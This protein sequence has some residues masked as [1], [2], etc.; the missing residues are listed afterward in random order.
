MNVLLL[1]TGQVP[2]VPWSE[3]LPEPVLSADGR[4]WQVGARRFP[5]LAGG[6]DDP[7]PTD[8]PKPPEAKPKEGDGDGDDGAPF[9]KER[10]LATIKKLRET[11]RLSKTQAKELED[12]RTRVKASDDAKLSD[13]ERTAAAATAEKERADKAETALRQER[14]E[15]HVERAATTRNFHDPDDAYR[16]IDHA[17]IE[18]DADGKPTNVDAL[19]DALVKAKP[20]LAKAEAAPAPAPAPGVPPTPKPANG[21]NVAAAQKTEHQKQFAGVARSSLWGKG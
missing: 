15:R 6:D 4:F 18:F 5:V 1:T 16:L 3:T 8:P 19:L 10:A 12:L 14:I 13:Q 20:H 11:E 2:N 21:Q 17:A 7:P 9:D